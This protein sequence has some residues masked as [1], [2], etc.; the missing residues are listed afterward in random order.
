LAL[1]AILATV[2]LLFGREPA[3]TAAEATPVLRVR[4]PFACGRAF[5]VSQAH[6]TGS[7]LNN[8]L[9]AWDFRMPEGVPIVAA[10]GGVVRMAR[11]EST[12]GGCD[13]RLARHANYVVIDHGDGTEAQYLHFSS[14]TVEAGQKVNE[15]EL[16]GYSGKTGWAC[17]SHL[18]FK[19]ARR[20]HNGWN[21]PSIPA[22]IEGFGDPD[23]RTVVAAP[24]C[25]TKVPAVI[26]AK[27]PG[28]SPDEVVPARA[29]AS[30][31]EK[32]SAEHAKGRPMPSG[33]GM[34]A[35]TSG[36]QGDR[37]VGSS[38]TSGGR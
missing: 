11:G 33:E 15:G 12:I 37:A 31:T 21:N 18:H 8:D 26:H 28:A 38:A 5:E 34:P 4:V 25:E 19:I 24:T 7:H 6:N 35:T 23:V 20:V 32:P 9:Y 1:I 22:E 13:A 3:V 10:R 14:V 29:S 2:S 17:G 16:I 36:R 30:A 27:A